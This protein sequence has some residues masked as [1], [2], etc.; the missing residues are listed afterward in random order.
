MTKKILLITAL[1]LLLVPALTA[2]QINVKFGLLAPFQNSD[3]WDDN[4]ENLSYD[5]VDFN[6]IVFFVEY[7]QQF[8]KHLS[9]YVE[10]GRFDKAVYAEYRDYEYDNGS[11]IE[12]S[13]NLAVSTIETG[14][15]FNLLPYRSRFSPY[16][17]GGVGL[18]LWQYEQQG[19]FI[20]FTTMDI[21]EGFSDQE[22]VSLGVHVKGGFSIRVSRHLGLMVEGKAAWAKGDLGRYFEGFEP[23][24]V[25]SLSLLAGFQFFF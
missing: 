14:F 7:Q 2:Q 5:K 24:D 19:D 4:Y 21:Y 20:D 6:D 3:L 1:T 25:G 15:K 16:V 8:H 13:M 17:A 10:G 18:Y 9:F 12:Q 23:F 22:T 11:P